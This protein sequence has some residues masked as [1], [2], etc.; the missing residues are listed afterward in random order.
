MEVELY[1]KIVTSIREYHGLSKDC[2]KMLRETYFN[3]P[4]NTLYSILSAEI[5]QKMMFKH[6]KIFGP[7]QNYYDS[8]L[9]AVQKGEPLSVI[10]NM[11]KALEV[12]PTLMARNILEQYCNREDPTT[13]Q[14][15]VS[16]LLKNTTLIEDYR[17]AQEVYLSTIYD[18]ICG[19]IADAMGASTGQEYELILQRYLTIRNISFRNEE[20]L[21]SR[22]YDKTPDFKLEVPIAINGFIVNW[23]ESK[24]RFGSPEVHEKYIEKQFLS[25]WNRFGPGLVIYWFGYLSILNQ[26]G[27]KKFIIM[28]EFPKDITYMDPDSIN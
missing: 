15:K 28:S 7:K 21:R 2:A 25:Y 20:Y 1:N 23:I 6:Y 3:V 24:A 13:S 17:L 14:K 27:E 16:R 18:D 22:G 12:P 4:T 10:L 9:Q 26:P 11:A 8:Y 5:Q 19:P